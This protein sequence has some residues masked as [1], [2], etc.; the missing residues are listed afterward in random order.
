ME[1]DAIISVPKAYISV[2]DSIRFSMEF[3]L[4]TIFVGPAAPPAMFA[5]PA[6]VRAALPFC[7]AL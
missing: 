2:L 3:I 7:V 4:P 6:A 1:I 5:G